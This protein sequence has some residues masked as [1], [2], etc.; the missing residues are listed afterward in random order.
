MYAACAICKKEFYA[1]PSWI[2]KG[3]GKYC[4]KRCQFEGQK[5]GEIKQCFVCKKE[6][7]RSWKSLEG[8]ESKKYFCGKSC[9]AIWRNTAARTG[10]DHPNWKGGESSYKDILM[11]SRQLKAC[12]K[13]GIKDKRV[14]AVHHIDHDRKNNMIGNL[15]WLCHN[16]HYLIH[17]D[18]TE[19]Q[20]FMETLV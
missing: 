7:Y 1:K 10:P 20:R 18:I 14:L 15:A 4:S 16:C 6:V 12:R 19:R 9:Q 11:R 2:R 3:W 13:C 8:S 17:H 5:N